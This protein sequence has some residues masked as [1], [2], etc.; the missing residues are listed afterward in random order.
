MVAEAEVEEVLAPEASVVRLVD[1]VS[2]H[3]LEV[4]RV[5]ALLGRGLVAEV[6]LT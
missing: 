3:S 6:P 2:R 4:H 1:L 5:S